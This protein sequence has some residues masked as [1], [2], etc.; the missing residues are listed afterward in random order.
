MCK[1]NHCN[2]ISR[3]CKTCRENYPGLARHVDSYET[4]MLWTAKSSSRRTP[5]AQKRR[6]IKLRQRTRRAERLLTA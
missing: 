5:K 1:S 2:G 6:E 4:R 3:I